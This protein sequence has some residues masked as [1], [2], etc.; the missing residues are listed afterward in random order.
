[1]VGGDIV[2][3]PMEPAIWIRQPLARFF[4]CE[5]GLVSRESSGKSIPALAVGMRVGRFLNC[6][7]SLPAGPLLRCCRMG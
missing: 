3:D 6:G 5:D 4:A 2:P 7:F 1:M